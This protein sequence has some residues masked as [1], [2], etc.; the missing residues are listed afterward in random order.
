MSRLKRV[1]ISFFFLSN[2]RQR[3]RRN[4]RGQQGPEGSRERIKI[5]AR[6]GPATS[7]LFQWCVARCVSVNTFALAAGGGGGHL[8]CRAFCESEIQ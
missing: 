2:A 6:V 5:A 7:Y 8:S 1:G 3:I 4:F